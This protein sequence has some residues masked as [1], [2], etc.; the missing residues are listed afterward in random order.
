M[1]AST[2]TS[3]TSCSINLSKQNLQQWKGWFTE[4]NEQWPG[5]QTN[6]KNKNKT[7]KNTK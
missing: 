6:N 5:K 2:E 7:I 1:S 4:V 3:S